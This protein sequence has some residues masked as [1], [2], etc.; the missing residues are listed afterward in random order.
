MTP[1]TGINPI[2]ECL[3]NGTYVLKGNLSEVP[4]CVPKTSCKLP[5]FPSDIAAKWGYTH[6]NTDKG[7]HLSIYSFALLLFVEG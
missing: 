4:T 3:E 2:Y 6:N 7:I 5:E 1:H